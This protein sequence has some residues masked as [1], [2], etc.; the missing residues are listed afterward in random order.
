MRVI[1]NYCIIIF[2]LNRHIVYNYR[3]IC[4]MKCDNIKYEWC[5]LFAG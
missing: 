5:M 1:D 3:Y 2:E 4:Y